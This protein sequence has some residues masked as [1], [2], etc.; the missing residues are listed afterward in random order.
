MNQQDSIVT[1]HPGKI[2]STP[3]LWPVDQHKSNQIQQTKGS[4][5]PLTTNVRPTTQPNQSRV[6]PRTTPK[7][8]NNVRVVTKPAV[9][10]QKTITVQFNHPGGDQYFA[11][12]NVYL[13]KGK[14]Q[15]AQVASGAKSPLTFTMPVSTAPHTV[16]VTSQ[17]NWGETPVLSSPSARVRVQ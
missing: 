11:G 17:G 1:P 10:G 15:P 13:K 4:A 16:I 14:G 9:N 2:P 5:K 12:A 6:S 7:P 3:I 8:V